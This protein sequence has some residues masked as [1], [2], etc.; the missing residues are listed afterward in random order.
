MPVLPDTPGMGMI[1]GS[2]ACLTDCVRRAVSFGVP[3]ED[4]LRAATANPAKSVGLY[5]EVGSLS[6]G[7]RADL[8]VLDKGLNLK[9]VV[10]GG[11]RIK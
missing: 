5:G 9:A 10:L 4:A 7:K 11:R 1:A 3:L 6:E 8:L 2:A